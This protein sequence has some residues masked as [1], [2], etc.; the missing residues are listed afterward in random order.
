[1]RY[2][3]HQ[4]NKDVWFTHA[5]HGTRRENILKA[6]RFTEP[7]LSRLG[8]KNIFMYRNPLDTAVSLYFQIHKH[9]L[10]SL[11][12]KLKLDYLVSA[13]TGNLPP[14][15][16][17]HFVLHPDFGVENICKF[18][19]AWLDYFNSRPDTLV[20]SYEEAKSDLPAVIKK[21]IAYLDIAVDDIDEIV[22]KSDFSEMKKFELQQESKELRLHGMRSEDPD[23]MKVR[24][25]VVKGYQDYLSPET[26]EAARK[27]GVKYGFDI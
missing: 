22:R 13:L 20:V 23:T 14:K 17:N 26:I 27:I 21:F 2:V 24:K 7:N 3:F 5:G 16:I 1:M 4:L 10:F 11:K 18:N 12:K 15:D 8:E 9:E 6:R 25:G 19:R